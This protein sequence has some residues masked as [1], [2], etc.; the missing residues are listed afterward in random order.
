MGRHFTLALRATNKASNYKREPHKQKIAKAT[1][2]KAG[3]FLFLGCV[4]LI[5]AYLIQVN[6]FSTKG[7]EIKRLQKQVEALR[8][9]NK[10]LGINSSSLQSMEQIQND[11]SISSMVSVTSI[12]YIHST[13]LTQR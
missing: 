10:K 7:Y 9:E 4:V 6:S 3:L 2:S 11:P 1:T 12:N 13:A 8:D 5:V